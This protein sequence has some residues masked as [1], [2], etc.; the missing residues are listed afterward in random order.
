MVKGSAK[1]DSTVVDT[2]DREIVITRVIDAPRELVFRAFT[3]L[4]QVGKWWGPRGFTT[5]THEMSVKPGGTWRFI[6]HG[7]DGTDWANEILYREVVKPERLVYDHGE[8]GKPA[9]FKVWVTFAE[10]AGKTRLTMRSLFETAAA[11][12]F[13]IREVKAIEGGNQTL[14]RLEAHLAGMSR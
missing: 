13:V 10:E 14:D 1:T 12:D 11:R 3:D 8:P 9:L 4:K 2:S 6:M 5:T 7:P